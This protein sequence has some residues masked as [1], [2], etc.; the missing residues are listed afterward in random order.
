MVSGFIAWKWPTEILFFL[1]LPSDDKSVVKS[2][3]EKD[4][5]DGG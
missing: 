3:G 4:K 2:R 1:S 5:D